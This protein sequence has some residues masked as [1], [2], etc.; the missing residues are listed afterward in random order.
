MEHLFEAQCLSTELKVSGSPMART[1]FVFDGS[2]DSCLDLNRIRT[3]GQ[4]ERLRPER[5]RSQHQP[6]AFMAMGTT[7][8]TTVGSCTPDGMGVIGPH[9]VA[10]DQR[11]L[12]GAIDEV[13]N[14]RN[15]DDR[16]IIVHRSS[17]TGA[18]LRTLAS[19]PP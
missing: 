16:I 11:T 3:T 12:P 2:N 19:C 4:P 5:N 14:R 9:A 15:R 17:F 8:D 13:L 7:A 18:R 10:V 6:T 1:G